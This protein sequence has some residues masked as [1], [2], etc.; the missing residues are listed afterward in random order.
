MNVD[1][2]LNEWWT[3]QGCYLVWSPQ[4]TS[5]QSNRE[6]TW[7]AERRHAGDNFCSPKCRISKI[8]VSPLTDYFSLLPQSLIQVQMIIFWHISHMKIECFVGEYTSTAIFLFITHLCVPGATWFVPLVNKNKL[9]HTPHRIMT[10]LVQNTLKISITKG[11]S[12][13]YRGNSF[14]TVKL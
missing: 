5:F 8:R 9:L 12:C 6:L 13:R 11:D 7:N 1:K 2:S 14:I 4:Q 10:D 3:H